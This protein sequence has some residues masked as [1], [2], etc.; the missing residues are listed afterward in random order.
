MKLLR[1]RSKGTRWLRTKEGGERDVA[2]RPNDTSSATRWRKARR[3]DDREKHSTTLAVET[4][5][6]FAAAPWLGGKGLTRL[7]RA[8]LDMKR[9]KLT[10]K[11]LVLGTI[12]EADVGDL[13][14]GH[15][16]IPMAK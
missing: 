5:L 6:G 12:N 1:K 11:E 16:F 2:L 9:V 8:S 15:H 10:D 7:G 14:E 4:V 3:L 13:A